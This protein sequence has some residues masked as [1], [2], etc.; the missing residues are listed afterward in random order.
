MQLGSCIFENSDCNLGKGYC[1]FDL[2]FFEFDLPMSCL[3]P[4][5][6]VEIFYSLFSMLVISAL[7]H[8]SLA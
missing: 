1:C 7:L 8:C 3:R 6:G 4:R 5:V 2:L